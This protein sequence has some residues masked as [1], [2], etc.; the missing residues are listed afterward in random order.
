MTPDNDRKRAGLTERIL[1][2]LDGKTNAYL[3]WRHETEWALARE[4]HGE[5]PDCQAPI[6]FCEC[7]ERASRD[8][9]YERIYD[10]GREHGW[11]DAE[12]FERYG[13]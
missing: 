10:A 7:A 4:L 1:T 11:E 8:D 3:L 12:R 6:P 5:C 2:W 13:C 9:I